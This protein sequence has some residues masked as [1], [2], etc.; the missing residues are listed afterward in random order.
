MVDDTEPVGPADAIITQP[1]A[2]MA[3]QRG[4][5]GGLSERNHATINVTQWGVTR[6]GGGIELNRRHERTAE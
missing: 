5:G 1:F 3:A 6:D 2:M 4:D